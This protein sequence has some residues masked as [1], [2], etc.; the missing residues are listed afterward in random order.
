MFSSKQARE[1]ATCGRCHMGPDHPQIEIYNESKHGI[2]FM[3]FREQ[4]ALDA[5]EWILGKTY[6]AAPTCATCHMSAT[7]TM[8]VTH[9][10]GARISWTL[11]PIISTKLE[12]WEEKRGR[13]KN[14]CNECHGPTWTNNY[15]QMY[16]DAVNLYNDKFAIP[17]KKSWAS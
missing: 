4:M 15:Y 2:M 1:P 10:V 11:R 12:N 16:D 6:T 5:D 17:A 7:Q 9:D 8:P 13:M 14:V 3:A